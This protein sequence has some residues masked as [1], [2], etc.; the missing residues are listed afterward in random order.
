MVAKLIPWR[1]RRGRRAATRATPG[2]PPRARR[3]PSSRPGTAPP[4]ATGIRNTV[5]PC[6]SSARAN[7]QPQSIPSASPTMPPSTAITTDSQRTMRRICRRDMPTTRSSPSSW[8]RSNT[9]SAS[10]LM[11][12]RMAMI[13][14]SARIATKHGE[15]LV[16]L[17]LLVV[18][19]L[20]PGSARRCWGSPR[21]AP[22]ASLAGWRAS[23]RLRSAPARASPAACPRHRR[24]TVAGATSS[25][26]D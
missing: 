24:S 2:T 19:E 6:S 17:L 18:P 26:T 7:A 10:V 14:D 23:P 21:R 8:V 15:E 13:S 4:R 22:A 1:S 25:G 5:M 12:P 3:R 16:D 20:A 9:D 11:I